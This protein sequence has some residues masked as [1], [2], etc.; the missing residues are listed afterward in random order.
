LQDNEKP[1]C[2]W[3]DMG[4]LVGHGCAQH[5]GRRPTR[6]VDE[7]QADRDG[8]GAGATVSPSV[9]LFDEPVSIEISH[10]RPGQLVTVELSSV[11]ADGAQWASRA[12]FM[13]DAS[14]EVDVATA[15]APGAAT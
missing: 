6:A 12:R 15:R 4:K 2:C 8:A 7:A 5:P 3:E 11:D 1:T 9:S 13:P 14:G 10:L